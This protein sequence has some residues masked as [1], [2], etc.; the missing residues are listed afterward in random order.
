MKPN[1]KVARASK[2]PKLVA[3]QFE[4]KDTFTPNKL[5]FDWLGKQLGYKE[6]N[7]WYKIS[8]EVIQEHGGGTLL[9]QYENSPVQ[10]LRHLYPEHEW[11]EWKFQYVGFGFWNNPNNQKNFLDWLGTQLEFKTMEDWHNISNDLILQYGG[12]GLLAY[13]NNSS[14]QMLQS[15]YPQHEWI[16]WKFIQVPSDYWKDT[17]NQRLFMDWLGV[18]LEFKV[19]EDWYNITSDLII[20]HGGRGLLSYFHSSPFEILQTLYPNY[21]WLPWKFTHISN[22][23]W[24]STS[25]QKCYLEW[26]GKQLNFKSMED[27]YSLSV[28]QIAKHGGKSILHH[29]HSI[30][31]MIQTLFPQYKWYP[32]KFNQLNNQKHFLEWLGKKM[33]FQSME[34]WYNITQQMIIKHG[35]GAMLPSFNYSTLQ[36]LQTMYP[37]HEW[38]PWKLKNSPKEYWDNEEHQRNFLDWL[39][40]Q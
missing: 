7:D 21:D 25:N 17:K 19:M 8:K 26:L 18:H 28:D 6:S 39:A 32:L 35:G 31:Q 34:D 24:K 23:Y 33:N 4:A 15:L 22:D 10:A 37:H 3:K 27:W 30:P 5:F 14:L 1:I 36:M 40:K 9:L 2:L 16:P 13:Y 11:L 38:V 12:R 20:K 29:H